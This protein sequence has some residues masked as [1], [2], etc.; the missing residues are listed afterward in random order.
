[1][2]VQTIEKTEMATFVVMYLKDPAYFL[3][4]RQCLLKPEVR[5]GHNSKANEIRMI[6]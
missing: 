3:D 1:M 2:E 6:G 4:Q 5:E